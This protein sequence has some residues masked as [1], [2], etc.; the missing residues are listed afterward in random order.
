MSPDLQNMIMLYLQWKM[1]EPILV[2]GVLV[3]VFL[4]VF[5]VTCLAD[6]WMKFKWWLQRKRLILRYERVCIDE[7]DGIPKKVHRWNSTYRYFSSDKAGGWEIYCNSE[8][9]LTWLEKHVL[10]DRKF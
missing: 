4:F 10:L 6:G 8:D 1:F 7:R 3:A 5:L 2:L 9:E